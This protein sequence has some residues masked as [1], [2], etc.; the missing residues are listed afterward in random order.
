[1][2]SERPLPNILKDIR[3][4]KEA[5][6]ALLLQKITD[7]DINTH[8]LKCCEDDP[9]RDFYSA[10]TKSMAQKFDPDLISLDK[11]SINLIA[12]IKKASPSKG[13]IREDFEPAALAKAYAAGGADAISCLTDSKYFQGCGEYLRLV[14][15]AVDLPVLRKDF[16]IHPAQLAEARI[17]GADAVLLIARMLTIDELTAMLKKTSELKMTALTEVHDEEDIEK[18]VQAGAQLIG[19]NNRDLDTFVVDIDTT[20]RLRGLISPEIPIVAES[21][22]FTHQQMQQMASYGVSA[23]LVGESLMR[24]DD[25]EAATRKLLGVQ[26]H[27]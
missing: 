19:I 5:E 17:I 14:R 1:M 26:S 23:A 25:V 9:P 7:V 21:G 2:M 13:I 8:A 12:E 15:D 24:N 4:T 27:T 3:A 6:I 18:A 11:M 16:L 10:V 22:I 20:E